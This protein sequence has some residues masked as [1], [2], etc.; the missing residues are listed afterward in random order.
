MSESLTLSMSLKIHLSAKS[1]AYAE[2]QRSY[3]EEVTLTL[4]LLM[5]PSISS[6]SRTT[7]LPLSLV[8]RSS[9]K[10]VLLCQPLFVESRPILVPETIGSES[11]L[12]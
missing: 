6:L 9:D 5:H 10:T 11:V 7:T 4:Y 1:D 8:T 2:P 3:A 12:L